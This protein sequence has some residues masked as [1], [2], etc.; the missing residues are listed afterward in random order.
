MCKIILALAAVGTGT[1]GVAI[2]QRKFGPEWTRIKTPYGEMLQ[3]KVEVTVSH[4]PGGNV[5][6]YHLPLE[7]GQVSVHQDD[8]DRS[9]GV[10]FSSGSELDVRSDAAGRPREHRVILG[11]SVYFDLDGNGTIDALYEPR[12]GGDRR[13]FIVF[14]GRYVEVEDHKN[15]FDGRQKWAPGRN[16]EYIFEGGRWRRN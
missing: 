12:G 4:S 7:K 9:I 8:D 2:A 13:P 6:N 1:A 14:E 3:R 11:N 16:E 15:A 10:R 5:S